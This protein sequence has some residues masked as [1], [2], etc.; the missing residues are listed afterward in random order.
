MA[1]SLRDSSRRDASTVVYE[2]AEILRESSL[3]S[4]RQISPWSKKQKRA[5]H[6]F[7]SGLTRSRFMSRVT[8]FLTLT[9]SPNSEFSTLN[10]H[11]EVFKKRVSRLFGSFEYCKVKTNEGYGVLHVFYRCE[12]IERARYS[13]LHALMSAWWS[14]IHHSPIVW[15]RIVSNDKAGAGYCAGQYLSSQKCSYTRL[16]WSWGWV[17]RGFVGKWNLLKF[18]MKGKPMKAI[19]R[20]WNLMLSNL[21]FGKVFVDCHLSLD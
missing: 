13:A 18:A 5:F 14:E 12:F 21:E 9:S 19:L 15:N 4:D 6:R 17:A 7:L 8:Y 16:S 11:W 10:D 2:I 20:I 1:R 3:D